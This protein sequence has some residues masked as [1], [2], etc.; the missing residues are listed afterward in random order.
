M[1]M[2]APTI[3]EHATSFTPLVNVTLADL[4]KVLSENELLGLNGF[5]SRWWPRSD[6]DWRVASCESRDQWLL[7]DYEFQQFYWAAEWLARCGRRKTIN[8]TSSSY[9][10]KHEAEES[11]G[12]YIA[13]G[14]LIAAALHLGFKIKPASNNYGPNVLLNITAQRYRPQRDEGDERIPYFRH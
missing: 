13:N 14:A 8:E 6:R 5:Y 12:H 10:L 9:N 1:K 3:D 11:A 2:T 7:S 4:E